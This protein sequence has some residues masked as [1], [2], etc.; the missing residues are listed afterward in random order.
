MSAHVPALPLEADRLIAEA[1]QRARRRR[2]G[3]VG[4]AFVFANG[5]TAACTLSGWHWSPPVGR[6]P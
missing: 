4:D 1:K 6:A 5:S 2:S 3:T